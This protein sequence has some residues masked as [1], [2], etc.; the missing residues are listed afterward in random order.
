MFSVLHPLWVHTIALF[1][2]AFLA[3]LQNSLSH[4]TVPGEFSMSHS[5]LWPGWLAGLAIGLLAL[6]QLWLSNRQL[7]VSQSYGH[8]CGLISRAGTFRRSELAATDHWLLWFFLGLPLGG[9]I[10]AVTASDADSLALT[11][12]MGEMYDRVLPQTF[13]LKGLILTGGGALMGVGARLAGGCTSGHVI[14]GCALLNPPSLLAG[15]LFFAGGLAAVQ[16]LFAS[17]I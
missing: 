14:S 15:A 10:A 6:T 5:I 17:F 13:W 16:M 8:L 7:G 4:V 9:F 2:L 1:V 12:S 11:F 3:M